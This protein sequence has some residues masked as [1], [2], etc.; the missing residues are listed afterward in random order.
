MVVGANHHEGAQYVLF[1]VCVIMGPLVMGILPLV[2]LA[3]GRTSEQGRV[4]KIHYYPLV[5]Y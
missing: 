3:T 2:D 4:H 1:I 5:P